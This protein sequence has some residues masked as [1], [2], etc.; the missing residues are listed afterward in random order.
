MTTESQR[1]AKRRIMFIKGEDFNFIAYNILVILMELECVN[2]SKQFIDHRKLSFLIDLVTV[3]QLASVMTTRAAMGEALGDRDLHSLSV[4]YSKGE[5]RKHLVART[6]LSLH[7]VGYIGLSKNNSDIG[8]N[9]WAVMDKIPPE[10]SASKLYDTE[11][12]R[13]EQLKSISRLLRSIKLST[14]LEKFYANLGVHVWH[15]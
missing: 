13:V 4:S 10:F 12:Q 15:T 3:P 9:S 7:T 6:M 1:A 14:F 2:D 5:S 11:R 8:L